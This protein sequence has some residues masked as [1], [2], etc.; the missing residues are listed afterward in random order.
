MPD[1]CNRNLLIVELLA[2]SEACD[3]HHDFAYFALPARGS[4]NGCCLVR[5]RASIPKVQYTTPL[6]ASSPMH[7]RIS[8]SPG[9]E[10]TSEA[11]T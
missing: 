1:E 5:F 11:R 4:N 7:S 9:K 6:L 3:M 2:R 10:S 8:T